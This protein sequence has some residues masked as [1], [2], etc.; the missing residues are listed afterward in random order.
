MAELNAHIENG[1]SATE[2]DQRR[3]HYGLYYFMFYFFFSLFY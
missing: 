1:V 2:A 3:Q